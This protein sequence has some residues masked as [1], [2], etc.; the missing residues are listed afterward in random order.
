MTRIFT[1]IYAELQNTLRDLT[2]GRVFIIRVF[3]R[4]HPRVSASISLPLFYDERQEA[5]DARLL[6]G[7]RNRTLVLGAGSASLFG[8][9]FTVS[10]SKSLK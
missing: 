6:N 2:T 1:L 8:H 10:R 7:G 5:H 3:L 9:D 4:S